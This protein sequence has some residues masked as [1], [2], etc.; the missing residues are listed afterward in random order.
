[1]MHQVTPTINPGLDAVVFKTHA[2]SIVLLIIAIVV[3]AKLVLPQITQYFEKKANI[4]TNILQ[5]GITKLV[6]GQEKMHNTLVDSLTDLRKRAVTGSFKTIQAILL[7]LSLTLLGCDSDSITIYTHKPVVAPIEHKIDMGQTLNPIVPVK[8]CFP[9]CNSPSV[10]NS[11]N[12]QCEAVA[13]GFAPNK[14]LKEHSQMFFVDSARYGTFSPGDE[15][16]EI[17]NGR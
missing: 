3:F 8:T 1:M 9:A 10:C 11:S 4:E 13:K 17:Y 2:L 15:I 6:E 7:I 12:G 5:N 16:K 14:D